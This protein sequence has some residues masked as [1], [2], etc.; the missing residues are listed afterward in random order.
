[1][2]KGLKRPRTRTQA[3]VVLSHMLNVTSNFLKP[4]NLGYLAALLPFKALEKISTR[5]ERQ[6]FFW[7]R[8]LIVDRHRSVLLCCVRVEALRRR[9]IRCTDC[10]KRASGLIRRPFSASPIC[11]PRCAKWFS[12]APIPRWWPASLASCSRRRGCAKRRPTPR[13]RASGIS[14]DRGPARSE[15]CATSSRWSS[16]CRANERRANQASFFDL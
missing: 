11:F 3:V 14:T 9:R 6:Q 2:L 1:M 12:R 7:T 8:E 15:Y 4:E 13:R 16:T 10:W 5:Q